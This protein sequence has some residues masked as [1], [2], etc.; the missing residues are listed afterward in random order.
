[1][2]PEPLYRRVVVRG[3]AD[4]RYDETNWWKSRTGFKS[5]FNSTLN[6]I[7]ARWIGEDQPP[8]V[9]WNPDEFEKSLGVNRNRGV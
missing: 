8:P 7:Y 4:R 2:L 9:P 1:M 6:L 3:L 5:L